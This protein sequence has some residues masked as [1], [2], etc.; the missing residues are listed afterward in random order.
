MCDSRPRNGMYSPNGT[1]SRF[2]YTGPGPRPGVHS[3]PA[4]RSGFL[5]HLADQHRPVDGMHRRRDRA[6]HRGILPGIQVGGVLRP[7]HQVRC[8][9]AARADLRGQLLGGRRVVRGHGGGPQ[10]VGQVPGV[11]HVALDGG[12]RGGGGAGRHRVHRQQAACQGQSRRPGEGQRGDQ[13]A[14]QP[15][16]RAG[17]QQQPGERAAGEREQEGEQRRPADGGPGRGRRARL[18]HGQPAPRER[19]RPPVAQRLGGDPPPRHGHRPG[20]QRQ[21]HPLAHGEQGEDDRLGDGQRGPGV[22]GQVDQ[23]GQQRNEQREP[24]Q[25]PD[26]E[27]G[28]QAPALQRQ[29]EQ[30][31]AERGQRP[32]PDRGKGGGEDQPAGHGGQQCP[33]ERQARLTGQPPPARRPGLGAPE[34]RRAPARHRMP[35]RH[36]APAWCPPRQEPAG[37]WAGQRGCSPGRSA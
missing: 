29:H 10:Q 6:E 9:P 12:D 2:T 3:C 37:P 19:V 13:A 1:S 21:Q 32:R 25:Q 7:D 26:R 27:A 20:P 8:G 16:R 35:E 24:E 18:A 22:P 17:C 30:R 14:A 28:P 11:R 31:R 34:Y 15:A 36:Q 33:A 23:P 5:Q 4:L